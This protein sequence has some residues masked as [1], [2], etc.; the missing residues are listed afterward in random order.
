MHPVYVN[1]TND[2]GNVAQE[3]WW[4][5]VMSQLDQSYLYQWIDTEVLQP[6]SGTT[7]MAS[8]LLTSWDGANVSGRWLRKRRKQKKEQK[9]REEYDNLA[10]KCNCIEW[11]QNQVEQ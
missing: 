2:N 11:E 10:Q 3:R 1:Q 4:A 6:S 8:R 5:M 9:E 7:I